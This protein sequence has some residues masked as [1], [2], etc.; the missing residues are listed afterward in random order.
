MTAKALLSTSMRALRVR[1]MGYWSSAIVSVLTMMHDI[2]KL[3]KCG[4]V[5]ILYIRLRYSSSGGL[6]NL[7]G[8]FF[9]NSF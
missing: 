9:K 1:S 4:L 8:M 6:M 2:M 5:V 7:I 3:S